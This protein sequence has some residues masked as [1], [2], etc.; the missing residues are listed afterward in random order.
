MVERASELPANLDPGVLGRT[1]LEAARA[2][3][4]GVTVTYV[5]E[6]K[7]RIVY[8]SDAAA[9]ILG[10]SVEEILTTAVPS[11][12]VAADDLPRL[13]ERV[14]RW[15]QGERGQASLELTVMRKDGGRVPIEMSATHASIEGQ[16]VIF[17]FILDL[18]ARKSAEEARYRSEARFREL[19]EAAPEPIGIF[20][21]GHFAYANP[22]LVSALGYAAAED[23]YQM[24]LAGLVVPEEADVLRTREHL[25]V[26]KGLRLPTHTYRGQ[27]LDGSVILLEMTTVPMEYE[28]EPAAL[29]MGR[30][31][32]ARRALEAQLVQSD[33]LAA[34]GTMAAG[35]AHEV[36]NPLAYVMLNLEWIARKLPETVGDPASIG[37]LAEVLRE[38]RGGVERVAAIVRELRSFSRADG[39]TRHAVD[40]TSVAQSAIRMAAHEIR[41]RAKVTTSFAP[42][43]AVWAN[44]ARLEQVLLNL[45]LNAAQ[46]MPEARA[47]DNEIRISIRPDDSD[48]AVL[49]VSDNGEGIRPE[50]LPRIFDPFFT[51]KAPGVGTGLGLS[52][53]HG[54]VTSLGGRIT[55]RSEGGKGTTFCVILPTTD[56]PEPSM[57][58]PSEAPPPI[59][60][61]RARVLVVDD[62]VPIANTM[63][64]LLGTDHEVTAVTSGEGALRAI[65]EDGDFDVVFC[66]L[67]M[68][69][70]SGIDLFRRIR[71]LH[72]G[73]EERM[74]FMT[75]GA[76]TTRAAE[77]LAS[78]DNR[79]IE[80][81]F[82]LKVI[83]RIVR[84]MVGPG[85]D[86]APPARGVF[87]NVDLGELPDEPEALY[88]SAHVANIACGGHA[89]DE[90]T[91]R[92]AVELCRTFGVNVGAH[93]SYPDREGFGR[94]KMT[95]T[96]DSLRASV[97]G[98][99]A[100]LAAVARIGG[101]P[102]TFLKPHGALYHSVHG[103]RTLARAF[104]EGA[105]ESLGST[106]TVI[107][108]AQGALAEEAGRAG[109]A[110]A[111]E[112]FADRA[113]RP[114]GSLVARGEPG[115]L[116][117]DP[118]AAARGARAVAERR[119]ADTVCVHGDTPGAV[120][121]ARAVRAALDGIPRG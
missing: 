109:L 54:I 58:P 111:R 100:R 34:L 14:A 103:D 7:A 24:P 86:A 91:M 31:V 118:E 107:G 25:I 57:R 98:Q 44:E 3:H 40:L 21:G 96:P 64:D 61:R 2:A 94:T 43:R 38:A 73:L 53:C 13:R 88:A 113:A 16:P 17:A 36:N 95:M 23:L 9:E 8:A 68:P 50:I 106:I 76:F 75:G 99:C 59:G 4:I 121:I 55:A 83:E 69:G 10:R 108:P 78:I 63:R 49:E 89:G 74:V 81:P 116:V 42:V 15:V 32:T 65:V 117:L 48:N 102:V 20:R 11:S 47:A 93:P 37:P 70:M 5:N 45:L 60:H 110:Y 6:G 77:F 52:I 97:A 115:A 1:M 114:D 71:E 19:I 27:R 39:E 80:K 92:R 30:D 62:E 67:M 26:D 12:F 41:H 72:A 101:H 90:E 35:V 29:T 46:A 120:E 66:D 119:A 22:A 105:K 104:V 18:S 56:A 87:L 112:A 51:T 82:S 85:A 79:R 84:D 33:R 28:G